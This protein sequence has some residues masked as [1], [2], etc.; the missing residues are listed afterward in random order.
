MRQSDGETLKKPQWHL[1]AFYAGKRHRS[2][3]RKRLVAVSR[4]PGL[5]HPYTFVSCDDADLFSTPICKPV[6]RCKESKNSEI[7]KTNSLHPLT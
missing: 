4:W 6:W 7:S 2:R 5:P 3:K 1:R